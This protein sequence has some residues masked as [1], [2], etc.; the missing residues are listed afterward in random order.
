M[1]AACLLALSAGAVGIALKVIDTGSPEGWVRVGSTSELAERRVT[2][3]REIP[4]YVVDRRSGPIALLARSPQNGEPVRYCSSSGWFEDHRHGSMF[5]GLGRYVLG[6][7]PRGLGRFEIHVID[8][9]V[10]IDTTELFIGQDRGERSLTPAGP[11]CRDEGAGKAD[12]RILADVP[13]AGVAVGTYDG[14]ALI[15]LDGTVV[16]MLKGYEVAGNVGAEGVWFRRGH[17]LF[18]FHVDA[19]VRGLLERVREAMARDAMYD[20]GPEPRLA[21]PAGAAPGQA[22]AGHWRY[23]VRS[24]SGTTLAQWS[25]ECEVPMAYWIERS[26]PGELVTGGTDVSTAPESVALGWTDDGTAVVLL[27]EGAC[28]STARSPGVYAYSS[29][30]DGRLMYATRG[31]VF[32]DS[33]GLGL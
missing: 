26:S 4:A 25:G 21:S 22:P 18:R 14:V 33:W 8:N 2:F 30:G 15:D 32:V 31:R 5:D 12:V 7:A 23:A 9:E 10:W 6:P 11:F 13:D 17:R 29:P 28:G 19:G 27:P 1:V 3:I 20:E 16:A 24:P